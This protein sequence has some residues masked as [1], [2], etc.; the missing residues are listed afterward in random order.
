MQSPSGS[1]YSEGNKYAK[2][3]AVAIMGNAFTFPDGVYDVVLMPHPREYYKVNMH[4]TRKLRCWITRNRFSTAP[5]S[6]L[7]QRKYEALNDALHREENVFCEIA[8]MALNAWDQ[9]KQ[10]VILETIDGIN[11]RGDCSD[12]YLVGLLGMLYR[13]GQD[14]A[15][16]QELKQP[17]QDCILNFKYWSDEPGSDSMWYWSENHSILFHTCE[18]LAGQLY[19]EHTFT[20]NGETGQQHREK[21]GARAPNFLIADA[22][23]ARMVGRG[24]ETRLVCMWQPV[25]ANRRRDSASRKD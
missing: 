22:R 7:T 10:K 17:L 14:P 25:M 20:K 2:A 5:Y 24:W 3:G 9:I 21:G 16:T 13:F 8:K 1:I 19:P 15:F 18:V 11:H 6:D 12:F 23:H 4:I